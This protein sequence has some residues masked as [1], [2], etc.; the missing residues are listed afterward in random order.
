[1]KIISIALMALIACTLSLPALAQDSTRAAAAAPAAPVATGAKSQAVR[2]FGI[3]VRFSVLDKTAFVLQYRPSFCFGFEAGAFGYRKNTSDVKEH[4]YRLQ[5]EASVYFMPQAAVH[6]YAGLRYNWEDYRTEQDD[7]YV[8][9][10]GGEYRYYETGKIRRIGLNVGAEFTS[11]RF[12]VRMG[13]TPIYD[14][15][16]QITSHYPAYDIVYYGSYR[17]TADTRTEKA[18]VIEYNNFFVTFRFLF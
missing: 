18:T 17:D 13:V 9:D 7:N 16:N 8:S 2:Q 1:M 10:I 12:N 15:R 6:P 11:G 5:G 3:G 4:N 14:S